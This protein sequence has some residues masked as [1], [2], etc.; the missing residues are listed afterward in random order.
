MLSF[1]LQCHLST[2][3]DPGL[4]ARKSLFKLG[5]KSLF[6]L[7]S[8]ISGIANAGDWDKIFHVMAVAESIRQS[9][10]GGTTH[11]GRK[12]R[13]HWETLMRSN[14]GGNRRWCY[15][16]DEKVSDALA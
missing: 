10:W 16:L 2:L 1:T 11:R 7:G 15:A 9:H 13:H 4:R 12:N 3:P 8:K 5:S 14:K 6:M